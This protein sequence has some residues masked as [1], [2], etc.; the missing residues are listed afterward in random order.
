[1]NESHCCDSD[2]SESESETC[3]PC[4]DR[5]DIDGLTVVCLS[6]CSCMCVDLSA[7]QRTALLGR[8]DS[9]ERMTGFED[10]HLSPYTYVFPS[11]PA[12][13]LMSNNISHGSILTS[14]KSFVHQQ[15]QP[16]YYYVC[17]RF[18]GPQNSTILNLDSRDPSSL[19][20]EVDRNQPITPTYYCATPP[21]VLLW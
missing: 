12:R 3:L 13:S 2:T 19:V 17:P 7:F 18:S 1:M 8:Y 6:A 14:R 11:N 20:K 4:R 15:P 5:R 10:N 16:Q 9:K 21:A